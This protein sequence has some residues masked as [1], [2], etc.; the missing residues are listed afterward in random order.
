[1]FWLPSSSWYDRRNVVWKL[2][3]VYR[4]DFYVSPIPCKVLLH[5]TSYRWPNLNDVLRYW[6]KLRQFYRISRELVTAHRRETPGDEVK[7]GSLAVWL[8]M[9]KNCP[10]TGKWRWLNFT[11]I[12]VYVSKFLRLNIL[13]SKGL[14]ETSNSS[15]SEPNSN[16]G[17]PKLS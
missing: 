11:S 15:W 16:L 3:L 14:G 13:M 17:G 9:E 4:P 1:M 2:F 5:I 7:H 6:Y 8:E 12:E 10:E